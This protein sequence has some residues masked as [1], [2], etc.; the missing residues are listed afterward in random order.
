MSIKY[1]PRHEYVLYI[2]KYDFNHLIKKYKEIND[3]NEL[4]YDEVID[5]YLE[6]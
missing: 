4:D 3:L 5:Y 1:Y 6:A 2:P